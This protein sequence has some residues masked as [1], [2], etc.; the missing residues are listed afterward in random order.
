M[1]AMFV[2][3]PR[4]RGNTDVPSAPGMSIRPHAPDRRRP[5]GRRPGIR[6]PPVRAACAPPPRRPI[7]C[8]SRGSSAPRSDYRF[9]F[10]TA[11]GWTLLTC[12]FYGFYVIV[13]ARAPLT[14]SQPPPASRCSTPRPRS[15][16]SRPTASGVADEL[17]P[18]FGRISAELGVLRQPGRASSAIRSCGPLISIIAIDD[19]ARHRLHPPRRRPRRPTTAPRRDRARALDHL[20]AAR[21]AGSRSP[22]RRG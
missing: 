20:H 19:R 17:Q 15:R 1:R 2:L 21:R 11:F 22:I 18:N 3:L 9:D 7:G 14:R 16:G 5:P 8:A 6:R 12:G 13:P 10:W 4:A